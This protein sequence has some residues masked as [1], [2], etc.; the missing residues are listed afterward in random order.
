MAGHGDGRRRLERLRR[1]LDNSLPLV[2]GWLRRRAADQLAAE[3]SDEAV[4]VLAL[5]AR[6]EGAAALEALGKVASEG[7]AVARDALCGLAAHDGHVAARGLALEEDYQPRAVGERALYFFL[8]EQWE[9]YEDLDFDQGLLRAAYITA[10]GRV[11]RRIASAARRAG[12]LEWLA[13]VT[14]SGAGR[15]VA[16][17]SAAEWSTTLEVLA[18]HRRWADAWRLAQEAPPRWS[19]LLLRHLKHARWQPPEGASQWFH[20]LLLRAAR[21]PDHAVDSFFDCVAMLPGHRDEVRCLTAEP[22][23]RLLASAGADGTARLWDLRRGKPLACLKGHSGPVNCVAIGDKWMASAGQDGL[24]RLWRLPGGEAGPVLEGHEGPVRALLIGAGAK[25]LVSAGSDGV[26]RLWDFGH[27]QPAGLL[28]GHEGSVVCLASNAD[29]SVL[30]SGGADATVRLWSLPGGRHLRT[31]R[32]HRAEELD[33]VVCLAVSPDGRMLASGGTDGR[34]ALWRLPGG[35]ALDELSEHRA[36]VT[37][38]AFAAEGG[39]LVSGGSDQ[40]LLFWDAEQG[41]LLQG[42]QAHSGDVTALALLGGGKIVASASGAGVGH[43]HRVRLWSLPNGQPLGTLSG[44]TRYISCL[45]TCPGGKTLASAGGDGTIRQWRSELA[46]L[47]EMPTA[48]I[49]LADLDWVQR[50]LASGPMDKAQAD[51]LAFMAALLR[52]RR[53]LDVLVEEAAPLTVAVGDFDIEIEG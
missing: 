37:S 3:G 48:D 9:R 35:Q 14:R 34:V 13:V 50:T 27:G 53:R 39:V 32:G 21:W 22:A 5:A 6:R 11:R 51:A 40:R 44:H 36:G 28:E 31:L 41:A 52:W 18:G 7:N 33:A 1:W 2:G 29:G 26:V 19:A 42:V 17:L 15:P 4:A 49:S 10:G 45:L 12:R 16:L 30:A 8:T 47:A 25:V 38:L 23:G 43:D 20:E 24:V 46:R